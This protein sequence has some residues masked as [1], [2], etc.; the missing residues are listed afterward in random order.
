MGV[1]GNIAKDIAATSTVE[2][3]FFFHSAEGKELKK[4]IKDIIHGQLVT[5]KKGGGVL[6]NVVS[7]LAQQ[8]SEKIA[9]GI[10]HDINQL[11]PNALHTPVI[12]V[13]TTTYVNDMPITTVDYLQDFALI[14]K[15]G[16]Y[17]F[18]LEYATTGASLSWFNEVSFAKS[19]VPKDA[20]VYA[21]TKCPDDYVVT[22]N[23]NSIGLHTNATRVDPNGKTIF[24]RDVMK[25]L[26]SKY[27][28]FKTTTKLLGGL[29]LTKESAGNVE[30]IQGIR[31][32]KFNM[33]SGHY[34]SEATYNYLGNNEVLSEGLMDK[35]FKKGVKLPAELKTTEADINANKTFEKM[36]QQIK[37]YKEN[38][39]DTS[40]LDK[41][42]TGCITSAYFA[43]IG[44][45]MSKDFVKTT[46]GE[47]VAYRPFA[48]KV[49]KA[50]KANDVSGGLISGIK[51]D[52]ENSLPG[53]EKSLNKYADNKE[54]IKFINAAKKDYE[55]ANKLANEVERN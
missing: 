36:N 51:R 35:L 7:S 3:G 37:W 41:E 17:S 21:Y 34:V 25:Y 32:E 38:E 33:I 46:K 16:A 49:I 4:K 53:F 43:C 55:A 5:G 15:N 6:N 44:Y 24:Y 31:L 10:V 22:V 50:A 30:D 13:T 12:K 45:I 48:V 20:V 54:A 11:S 2:E 40:K 27:P 28:E 52:I 42:I 1:Y 29:K 8:Y 18:T 14:Y 9:Q 47:S 26:N 19:I 39:A 23:K